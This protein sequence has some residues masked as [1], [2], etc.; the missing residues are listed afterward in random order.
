MVTK[1]KSI[2]IWNHFCYYANNGKNQLP[3]DCPSVMFFF[4]GHN[5]EIDPS[6]LTLAQRELLGEHVCQTN[7][8]SISIDRDDWTKAMDSAA[9]GLAKLGVV[10]VS[11]TKAE[12]TVALTQ[13]GESWLLSLPEGSLA[14]E[15]TRGNFTR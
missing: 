12:V 9:N 3:W 11:K 7:D 15:N 5:L 13:R 1:K 14:T 2:I 4:M 6:T 10:T 8:G